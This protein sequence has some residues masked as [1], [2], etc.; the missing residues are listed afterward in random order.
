MEKFLS[1]DWGTSSFRLKL[2]DAGSLRVI[3][4]E[5]SGNGIARAFEL[6]KQIKQ[7]ENERFIFYARLLMHHI[8]KLEMKLSS[9]L[10]GTPVIISG[11][12]S[13]NI[14]MAEIPYKELPFQLDGSDLNVLGVNGTEIFQ[15]DVLIISGARNHHDAM[16]GEETQLIGCNNLSTE[17]EMYIFPGTHSKHILTENGMAVDCKTYMT[18]EFFELLSQ[19]SIL[20]Q[21]I[22]EGNDLMLENNLKSFETGVADGIQLN[23][24]NSSFRVRTNNLFGKLNDI[25]NYY[26]LSGLLIGT[27]LKEIINDDPFNI[28]IVGNVEQLPYYAEAFRVLKKFSDIPSLKF[29]QVEEATIRGQLKIFGCVMA[30]QGVA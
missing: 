20:A 28:T 13:S 18:G 24:L 19:K 10:S 22:E 17:K 14:G 5:T 23:L 4:A 16:R 11:M 1:C 25:E 27:E 2:V 30:K 3:G 7:A 21:S 29:Q 9:P 8:H 6:W 12:A 26:Y 15:H